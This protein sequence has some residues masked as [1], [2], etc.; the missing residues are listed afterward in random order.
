MPSFLCF[1]K[2][3]LTATNSNLLKILQNEMQNGTA[4]N[5]Q[6]QHY[7]APYIGFAY[8]GDFGKTATVA[9]NE[10]GDP[11]DPRFVFGRRLW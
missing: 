6:S 8:T 1:L 5:T 10:G 4:C 3:I 2:R 9:R 11:S 7:F